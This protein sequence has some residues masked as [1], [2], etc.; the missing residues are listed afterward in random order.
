MPTLTFTVPE[1]AAVL[2]IDVSGV[3]QLV[4]AGRLRCTGTGPSRTVAAGDVLD[5]LAD[6]DVWRSGSLGLTHPT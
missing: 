5:C 3:R 1:S 2:G 4:L 6:D